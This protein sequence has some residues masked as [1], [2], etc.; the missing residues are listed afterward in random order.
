M[1]LITLEEYKSYNALSDNPKEDL[2]ISLLISSVSSLIQAY[3]KLDFIGGNNVTEVISLDY[4]TNV[5]YLENYPVVGPITVTETDRYTQDSSVHV[6]LAYASEYILNESLGTLTRV[7][8]PGGFAKWPVSPGVVTVSYST[9]PYFGTGFSTVPPDLKL[10]AIELVKYY[11]K[12]DY[13]QSKTI[14]GTSIVNTLASGTDFP[15]HIQVLLD[16][17]NS[18]VVVQ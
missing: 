2:K 4:D 5:I 6:P 13:R 15:Q 12:E 8:T 1:D 7:Y 17:Y 3:L 9:A 18:R 16:R 14:Q 10:A 11:M